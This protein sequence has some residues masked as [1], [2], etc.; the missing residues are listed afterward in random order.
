MVTTEIQAMRHMV[1]THVALNKE[2]N[3][4]VVTD[5]EEGGEDVNEVEERKLRQI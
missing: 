3:G 4:R 1:A 5:G 2:S